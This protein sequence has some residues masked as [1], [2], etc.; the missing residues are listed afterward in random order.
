[1]Q[2]AK[3]ALA[4]AKA[5]PFDKSALREV[6]DIK[7]KVESSKAEVTR[8][9]A[10]VSRASETIQDDREQA[11]PVVHPGLNGQEDVSHNEGSGEDGHGKVH[12]TVT[13]M[14][15]NNMK[16]D[17]ETRK[18]TEEEIKYWANKP[19]R[20]TAEDPLNENAVM[21][22]IFQIKDMES[23][24]LMKMNE[25]KVAD[26]LD[27]NG[28][29]AKALADGHD[30]IVGD[31]I[32]R[33]NPKFHLNHVFQGQKGKNPRTDPHSRDEHADVLNTKTYTQVMTG[34][35]EIKNDA[36][37]EVARARHARRPVRSFSDVVTGTPVDHMAGPPP[38]LVELKKQVTQNIKVAGPDP[39]AKKEKE[40]PNAGAS[41]KEAE[42]KIAGNSLGESD[43]D[44]NI[45]SLAERQDEDAMGDDNDVSEL[46]DENSLEDGIDTN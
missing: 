5:K 35:H 46:M 42:D 36:A 10:K 14:E 21:G 22:K 6:I 29:N 15:D 20:W 24:T 30:I 34:V 32:V 31:E 40:Q 38:T 7:S 18:W 1:M 12:E 4:T 43:D 23:Q 16:A 26:K 27:P 33:A 44:D 41:D 2:E 45:E 3:S 13:E 39:D 8:L 17:P 11:R 19:V 37:E 9:A 28:P 25:M